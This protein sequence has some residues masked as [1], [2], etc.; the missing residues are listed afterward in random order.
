MEGVNQKRNKLMDIEIVRRLTLARH[1]YELGSASLR[2]ANDIHLFSA[3]NLFQDSVEAFL[4]A[5]ADYVGAALDQHTHFDQYFVK[6]NNQIAPKGLPFK[7]KLI[8]LNNIRVSSKHYGIQPARDECNRLALTIREFFDEVSNVLL[9]VTFSS[10]SAIDL[11][12]DGE[13]K[14]V[15]LDAKNALEAEEFEVCAICCR[16][17]LFLEIERAYD[18]SAYKDGK[19]VGGLL[20]GFTKAP[21]FSRNKQYIDENI[22]DPT[23]FIV[24]DHSSVNEKLLTEGADNIAFWNVWR[25]TPEVY[26]TKEGNWVIKHEF[27]KL[28]EKVLTDKIEYIFSA[29]L[30][31]VLSIHRTRQATQWTD[32]NTYYLNLN[33]ENVPIYKKADKN[34]EETGRTPEG[35]TR[36]DT[37]YR[38]DGLHGDD[39]YWHIS[40]FV[41]DIYLSGFIHNDYVAG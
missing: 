20:G 18:I 19:P 26:K 10:V 11:L 40:H 27:S 8:R 24:Y 17:A 35:L 3:V 38:V 36:I 1:L 31:V 4:V 12:R 2:S 22:Y 25:L 29:T 33:Q 6:I 41:E 15:L 9:G 28:D 23:D 32:H 34:S 16:K 5:V 7:N 39:I 13:T 14:V 37:D 30:D 21:Y